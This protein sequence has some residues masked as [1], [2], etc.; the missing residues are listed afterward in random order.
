MTPVR[1]LILI[2]ILALLWLA[3]L[4]ATLIAREPPRATLRGKVLAKETGQPIPAATVEARGANY[5]WSDTV[6]TDRQ[7]KFVLRGVPV[8]RAMLQA[9]GK[10]HRMQRE[11]ELTLHEGDDNTVTLLA[12]PVAPYLELTMPQ[13]VVLPD[14]TPNIAL[15]GFTRSETLDLVIRRVSWEVLRN[16]RDAPATPQDEG[17]RVAPG[18]GEVVLNEAIAAAPK[19]L[20]GALR[21]KLELQPLPPGIYSLWI[22]GRDAKTALVFSVSRLGLVTKVTKRAVLAYCVDLVSGRPVSDAAITVF[23][24]PSVVASGKSDGAGLFRVERTEGQVGTPTG[25]GTERVVAES[26]DSVAFTRAEP[27]YYDPDR[28]IRLYLYTDRPIYRPGHTVAYKAIA[29]ERDGS[30][31]RVPEGLPVRVQV[32]SP[33][34]ALLSRTTAKT[35]DWG[36]FHGEFRLA[37][38]A[39]IGQYSVETAMGGG[40][41]SGS[42]ERGHV[43]E[44]THYFSV[45]EYRKPEYQVDVTTEPPPDGRK[46][47]VRGD[48]VGV[49]VTAR[50]FWGAPVKDAD[51]SYRVT[52][53]PYWSFWEDEEELAG[54]YS[55]ESDEIESGEPTISGEAR[56]DE[57]GRLS[58]RFPTTLTEPENQD[59]LYMIE[60]DVNDP[61]RMPVTGTGRVIVSRGTFRLQLDSSRWI[62]APGESFPIRIRTTNYDG[63]PRPNVAVTVTI[64]NPPAT[65]DQ[66]RTTNDGTSP[67]VGRSSLVVGQSVTTGADGAARLTVPAQKPGSIRVAASVVDERGNRIEESTW[68]WVASGESGFSD[69]S[70]DYSELE[71]VADKKLYQP[72]DTATIMIQTSRPGDAA[73]VTIEGREL[74]AARVVTL[75]S[76]STPITLP[77][78]REYQPNVYLSVTTVRGKTY[79]SRDLKLKVSPQEHALQVQVTADR[80]RAGPR[81]EIVYRI[82][83]RDAGGRP[84]PA[85]ASLGLVDESIYS[86]M[87]DSPLTSMK[88]FYGEQENRVSTAFSFPEIYLASDKDAGPKDVRRDFPDT[89]SWFPIIRTDAT[90]RATIRVRL[91]DTLTTWRATVRAHTKATQ[92]GS[93]IAK[94]ISTK[95]LLVRLETPRFFAQNDETLVSAVVHNDT[96]RAQRVTVSLT[97]SPLELRDAPTATLDVAPRG[98]AR[99]DWRVSATNDQR[100]TTN[101][102]TSASVGRSSLVVRRPLEATL[103]VAAKADSG[104]SD[105]VELKR[106]IVPHGTE[107]RDGASGEIGGAT[108]TARLTLPAGAILSATECRVTLTGSPV[109]VMLQALDYLHAHAFDTSE[110]AVG[111]FLPNMTVAMALRDL[112]LG[113][114]GPMRQLTAELPRRV[115]DNV[116]RIY[117]LQSYDGGW[118]WGDGSESNAFWTAYVLYGLDQARRAGCLIDEDVIERGTGALRQKWMKEPDESNR[119]LCLYVLQRVERPA[120]TETV[121]ALLRMAARAGNLQNYARSLVALALADLGET[122]AAEPVIRALHTGAKSKGDETWW[123]EIFPWGF[124]SCNDNETTAYAMM[125]LI[126]LDPTSPRIERAA[127]WL[128]RRREGSGWAST[129]DT[130][131]VIYGLAAYMRHTARMQPPDCTVTVRVNGQAAGQQRI[132]RASMF[133]PLTLEIDPARLRP[134]ANEIV[135]AKSGTGAPLFSA[136]LRTHVG[137]EGIAAASSGLSVKR[138]YFYRLRERDAN[139]IWQERDVPVAGALRPG[140]EVLVKLTVRAP[141]ACR[142]VI[143]RD[144]L[145]AGCEGLDP[146]VD[147]DY[148]EYEYGYGEHRREVRDRDVTFYAGLLHPGNNKFEY[149][150]RAQLPGD[151]HVMPTQA[152]AAYIPEI[153]GAGAEARVTVRE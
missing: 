125:A 141:R 136:Y 131:S 107:Q 96:D 22:T 110:N 25:G 137:S 122:E 35:N 58:F 28:P 79:R 80:E 51:V 47:Y 72:G 138:A 1:R 146:L 39:A 65:N 114:T 135:L 84:V 7:G 19:D 78:D 149:R 34:G 59:H 9:S 16:A 119:A 56:T 53:R 109:G 91:P 30:A 121:K 129:E 151:Y 153:W 145:P 69:S 43:S 132:T 139:G 66:R 32:R 36:S 92:V 40:V 118:G 71:L 18:V 41:V 3:V 115:G 120:Q 46:Q 82:R 102:S 147:T 111:W 13:R 87:P 11:Q 8:G 6:E 5:G 48:T 113:S 54:F 74:F 62:A 144:P 123:P 2:Q 44:E 124:Y 24:G 10:V 31:Y 77:I 93:G 99:R 57:N 101:D 128:M 26:G 20:E 97:A 81:Q 143:V 83:T 21:R 12:P 68:L 86:I 98:L 88:T 38:D 23:R 60:A 130:A 76:N 126:R 100:R 64:G 37:P 50:Y 63:T 127:R 104:L 150:F 55:A 67:D 29:R 106:P 95:P 152:Y 14:E 42:G 73:L 133:R 17:L 45:A 90:G 89:A 140:D 105:A 61:G 134:G 148:G 75:A 49:T 70:Y 33:S 116:A 117:R 4:A 85:E 52:R 15:S 112:G 27:Y 142:E 94:V 108:A 103:L